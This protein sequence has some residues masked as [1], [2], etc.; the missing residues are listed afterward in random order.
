MTGKTFNKAGKY[1]IIYETKKGSYDFP[2]TIQELAKQLNR[3]ER[4]TKFHELKKNMELG[5]TERD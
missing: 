2:Q 3:V 1:E 5:D 4:R